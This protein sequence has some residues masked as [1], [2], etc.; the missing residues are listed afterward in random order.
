MKRWILP[1]VLLLISTIA[2]AQCRK[3][4]KGCNRNKAAQPLK[5]T[6]MDNNK[7]PLSC[8]LTSP[9]LRKR[10]EEVIAQLKAQVIEKRELPNGYSYKFNGSD[11]LLDMATD[12]IKSERLCC[13]FFSFKLTITDDAVMWLDIYGQ[14]GAKEFITTE[15]EM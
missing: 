6:T 8:K 2:T 1:V 15:L 13:D 5:T 14:E 4:C 12:F 3:D 10:K 11:A 9:E 7:K